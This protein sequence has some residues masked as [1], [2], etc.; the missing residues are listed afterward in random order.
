MPVKIFL[1][2]AIEKYIHTA[3]EVVRIQYRTL[4]FLILYLISPE[5]R[6]IRVT[7]MSAKLPS[8]HGEALT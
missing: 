1:A 7:A 8:Y 6:S 2:P 4:N 3:V 5:V